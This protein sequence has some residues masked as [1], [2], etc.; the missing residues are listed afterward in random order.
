[1]LLSDK[2]EL[3]AEPPLNP[4]SESPRVFRSPVLLESGDGLTVLIVRLFEFGWWDVADWF[5]QSVVVEPVHPFQG[6]YLDVCRS[7][8]GSFVLD[9][10]GLVQADYRFCQ[11]VVVTV[12]TTANGSGDAG[13]R[14]AFAVT[15]S[16]VLTA[17]VRVMGQ[18]IGLPGVQRL[19]EG[20]QH[21]VG[22][23]VSGY[24]PA[25]Y[26]PCERVDDESCVNEPASGADVR[27]VR[28]PQGVG[29][30]S[31][32]VTVH[33]VH[34]A[35]S[36]LVRNRG[37]LLAAP[38]HALQASSSHEPLHSAARHELAF[39]VQFLPHLPRAVT[40]FASIPHPLDFHAQVSVMVKPEWLAALV[41]LTGLKL[42]INA[43]GDRQ[44]PADRLDPHTHHGADR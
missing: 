16:Q 3:L 39:P 11:G 26:A 42:V 31:R 30:L 5:E 14:Q 12:T 8:P 22:A 10:F 24:S 43:R 33:Q 13:S 20:V 28:H 37:D 6:G 25:D 1:M 18:T 41:P 32:E 21:E 4:V 36:S 38:G 44:L 34:R 15:D 35:I 9:N 40:L 29:L 23:Q 17:A 27:Q 7:V 19:I 2:S